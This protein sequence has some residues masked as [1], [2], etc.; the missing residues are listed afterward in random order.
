MRG[1]NIKLIKE[2]CNE[3]NWNDTQKQYKRNGD[4]TYQFSYTKKGSYSKGNEFEDEHGLFEFS[5][6]TGKLDYVTINGENPD[7]GAL[8]L[9]SLI[10]IEADTD[11]YLYAYIPYNVEDEISFEINNRG[12]FIINEN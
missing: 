10:R 8:D 5:Q 9:Y 1:T 4:L 6:L 3:F 7:L 11:C 12:L 2:P